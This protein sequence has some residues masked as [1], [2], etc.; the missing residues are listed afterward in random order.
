MKI[1]KI[2]HIADVHLRLY[3]RHKEYNQVFDTLFQYINSTKDDASCIVLAG[4]IV[5]NKTDMSPELINITSKF[6]KRCADTLPTILILGNHDLNVNNL[7]RLDALTPIVSSINH[8][9]LYFWRD[10]GIYELGGINWSV[11]SFWDSPENWKKHQSG[12]NIALFH[13]PVIGSRTEVTTMTTGIDSKVFDGFDLVLLGDI[14]SRQYLNDKKTIAYPGSL[15]QQDYG[16][17][18][19]NHGI[20]VWDVKKRKGQFIDIPN[21]YGFYTFNIVNGEC[22]IPDNLPKNL[23]VRIKHEGT[24]SSQLEDMLLNI[25]KRYN[26][27]EL[28]KQKVNVNATVIHKSE[29]LLNSSRDVDFQNKIITE[30]LKQNPDTTDDD[31]SEILALNFEVNKLLPVN[32]LS[33]NSI[34][35][36]IRLEFSNM[37]SY[38]DGN[39]VDFSNFSGNYGIF[40]QNAQ[41]KSALLDILSFVIYDKSTR[42]SKSSHILNN[43]KDR[44]YC[45]FEFLINE[46]V[47]YIERIGVKNERT[48]NVKVDVNFWTVDDSGESVSLNGED[49]DK[50]NFAIRNYL[51]TYDDFIMTSLSTQYDNQNFV[52]KS[53]RDRKELLYKF[54]DI[55]IYDDLYRLAKENSKDLQVLIRE[56]E[57]ENLHQRM[58]QLNSEISEKTLEFG[59]VDERF[60]QLNVDL[61]NTLQELVTLN[62]QFVPIE[63]KLNLSEIE[64]NISNTNNELQK[65]VLE[66]K[67]IDNVILE[68]NNKRVYLESELKKYEL[69]SDF[70]HIDSDYKNTES[71]IKDLNLKLERS[72][73]QLKICKEKEIMLCEHKY[74]PECK[75]CTSN[76][77]VQEAKLAIAQIPSLETE[78]TNLEHELEKNE[79]VLSNKAEILSLG[80]AYID[81]FS[82]IRDNDNTI[83]IEEERRKNVKYRGKILNDTMRSLLKQK[84]EYER[85]KLQIE[86]NKEIERNINLAEQRKTKVES[87]IQAC[88][89]VH[90]NLELNIKQLK[91][92]HEGYGSKL[93]KYLEYLKKYRIYEL[94]L[95]TVSRDGVPYKIVEMVLPLL[96]SEVNSILNSICNFTIRLEASDE[97][98][99]HAFIQYDNNQ[100]WPIELSCGMERF[101][102]SIAFRVA[103]TEI[104]SLP[105]SNFLAIDEGF[106][107][108]DAEN[109]LQIGKLFEYLR[110]QYDF[111]I[112]ISHIDTMRDLVD[113]H[114]KIDKINGY[115][116]ITHESN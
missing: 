1:N 3:K 37:F 113:K 109:I 60:T 47:Y 62:K 9:N 61:E 42:A 31:I 96:E 116:R 68:L 115:S 63:N 64:T 90:R 111:L 65:C 56:F 108:L 53:Q 81:I 26:I 77:F 49:R 106:G 25:G 36:P 27:N 67:N 80:H 40:N 84:S 22:N 102:L 110:N 72:K 41:G 97:K 103:L 114:I 89:K 85:N 93:Q 15:I 92:E 91:I 98:Y 88:N 5:H 35:K 28:V 82:K 69:Y 107:V 59:I 66:L 17:S 21:D 32:N 11:F 112:C 33:R 39:V 18:V 2:Y 104:T 50:T 86:K 10:S 100:S 70:K 34:W 14:H 38:G 94:Y 57:K 29:E 73:S 52:E 54:L 87:S 101:V 7:N 75:F 19:F 4:D 78:I 45:K 58:S 55:F 71:K 105:K 24:S 23:R 46:K 48:G 12:Y 8:P 16:E 99:I 74:D 30:L 6:L 51:G 83:N 95:Q 43:T 13:G 20:M 76:S 44:F 79:L